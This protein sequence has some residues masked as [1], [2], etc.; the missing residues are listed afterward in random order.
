MQSQANFVFHLDEPRERFRARRV[1]LRG[2]IATQEELRDLRLLGRT[3]RSLKL[4]ERPDVRRAFPNFTFATGF[5]DEVEPGDLHEG[6]LHFSFVTG[7]AENTA[8]E[9][10]SA[11][12]PAPSWPVRLLA[13]F[14]R[15]LAQLRLRFARDAGSRWNAALSAFLLEV[16]ISRGG[17]FR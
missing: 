7:G 4:E 17:G 11:P 13:K 9:Y 5:D 10:L 2:W 16:R 12:P 15:L 8:V 6:A 1:R 3:K 14:G